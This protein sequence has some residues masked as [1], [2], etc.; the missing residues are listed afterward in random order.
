MQLVTWVV[1]CAPVL[2]FDM[3][4]D[5]SSMPLLAQMLLGNFL[6]MGFAGF[7]LSGLSEVVV[8][9]IGLVSGSYKDMRANLSHVIDQEDIL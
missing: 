5:F 4:A 3:N 6:V 9:K 7:A 1:L 2:L 8:S